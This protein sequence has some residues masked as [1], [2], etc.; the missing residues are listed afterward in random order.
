M[1]SLK[2]KILTA[3]IA[4]L[5]LGFVYAVP[6]SDSFNLNTLTARAEYSEEF[7]FDISVFQKF[8]NETDT[9]N[10]V[11]SVNV[12]SDPKYGLNL[13]NETSLQR[14]GR[15]VGAYDA[16]TKTIYVYPK[17]QSGWPAIAPDDCSGLFMGMEKLKSVNLDGMSFQQTTKMEN[18]FWGCTNLT[19]IFLPAKLS[20]VTDLSGLFFN[21]SSLSVL[22]WGASYEKI[23]TAKVEDFSKLFC[24]CRNLSTLPTDRMDTSS[25]KYMDD[26]FY[27]CSSVKKVDLS[28]FDTSN[29]QNM[30]RMFFHCKTL[31]EIDISNF[32]TSKVVS[33]SL[34]FS[35]CYNLKKINMCNLMI[36]ADGVN[37]TD[38][39]KDS[40]LLEAVQ[41][42]SDVFK[43]IGFDSGVKHLETP[44]EEIIADGHSLSIVE[45]EFLLRVYVDIKNDLFTADNSQAF[46]RCTL[47]DGT[48]VVIDKNSKPS[49]VMGQYWG[50]SLPIAAKDINH[51]VI[52][53]VFETP[54]KKLAG[55]IISSVKKYAVALIEWYYRYLPDDA[56]KMERMIKAIL[57]Y[58]EYA[59]A[60]FSG[61][62]YNER[63]YSE[64]TYSSY[65]Y[66]TSTNRKINDTRY[67]GSSLLLKNKVILRHYFSEEVY[68][69]VPSKENPGYYYIEKA[70]NPDQFDKVIDIY[71]YDV[72]TYIDTVLRT[73]SDTRLKNLL[74]A[75]HEYSKAVVWAYK[76]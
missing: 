69:S 5:A 46:V 11:F 45:G 29:V 76:F 52:I 41:C 67:V 74:C 51:D 66:E 48:I 35:E 39:V 50:Y 63:G 7:L 25:A 9:E 12:L 68:Y 75:L 2:K 6:W 13:S 20:K 21:C 65:A 72:N 71:D 18:M 1:I 61:I 32:D 62:D 73:S 26:M 33:F 10:I 44:C 22:D 36:Q 17:D 38:F 64:S 54:D 19:Y 3:L 34:M 37:V 31:E 23:E 42:S 60:Y 30:Y 28:S 57:N 47:P 56:V 8:V 55:T 49:D 4:M 15:T 58:G 24:G 53:E 59:D 43:A 40:P 16:S 14:F 70:F 27:Q